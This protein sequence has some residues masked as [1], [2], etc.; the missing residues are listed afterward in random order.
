MD[1]YPECEICEIIPRIPAELKIFETDKWLVNLRDNDQTLLGTS[2][3]TLK[4]HAP[5]LDYLTTDEENEFTILRNGLFRALRAGFSPITFN[6][7]CLKNDAFRN[8][9][10]T[11]PP[12]ASHVHWHIKPRYTNQ[13]FMF[14]GETFADPGPGRY[15]N[16][17]PRKHVPSAAISKEIARVI[18]ANWS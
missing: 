5:E 7:S 8:A 17:L 13:P 6:T 14:E 11:T 18:R 3:I 12:E 15:L 1:V 4:R 2:F 16:I 9:P 10:D